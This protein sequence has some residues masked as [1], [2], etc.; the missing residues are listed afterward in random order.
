[1]FIG[2]IAIFY[3]RLVRKTKKNNRSVS[4]LLLRVTALTELPKKFYRWFRRNVVPETSWKEAFAALC[5]SY[6]E[7]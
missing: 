3:G 6:A 5:L 2:V 4:S 1:M 7:K